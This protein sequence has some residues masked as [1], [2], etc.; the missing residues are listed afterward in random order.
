MNYNGRV[1]KIDIAYHRMAVLAAAIGFDVDEKDIDSRCRRDRTAHARMTAYWLI[2]NGLGTPYEVIGIMFDRD[3]S[4]V[5]YGVKKIDLMLELGVT[6]Y[7]N[8]WAKAI[9]ESRKRFAQFHK[10]RVEAEVERKL[11]EVLNVIEST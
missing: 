10:A 6:T 7:N 1:G 2:R 4:G 11:K 3:H 9:K 8:N 5:M